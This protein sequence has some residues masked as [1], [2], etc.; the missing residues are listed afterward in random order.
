[1]IIYG[2]GKISTSFH[3]H[4]IL[5]EGYQYIFLSLI[6]NLN[7]VPIAQIL[8]FIAELVILLGLKTEKA[9]PAIEIYVTARMIKY[10]I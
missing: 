9:N 7:S 3:N 10:S 8:N 2:E 5:K 4:K 6:S 1:M